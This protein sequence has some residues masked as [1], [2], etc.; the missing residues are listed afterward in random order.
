MPQKE[1]TG[2]A[3]TVDSD[4]PDHMDMDMTIKS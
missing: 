2:H 1:N 4:G 3:F